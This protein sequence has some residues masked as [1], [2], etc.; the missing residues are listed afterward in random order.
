VTFGG[1][2][3]GGRL[4]FHLCLRCTWHFARPPL[5]CARQF[6]WSLATPSPPPPE[7]FFLV[8]PFCKIPF[9]FS[10]KSPKNVFAHILP[11]LAYTKRFIDIRAYSEKSSSPWKIQKE[12]ERGK[13][14]K[15][16]KQKQKEREIL[17]HPSVG[18][19]A[20]Q[21]ISSNR[22]SLALPARS[23]SPSLSPAFSPPT[24]SS[25]QWPTF[26]GPRI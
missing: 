12:R 20:S 1:L 4:H 26:E 13:E 22:S 11:Y 9:P 21:N 25:S 23:F 7:P 6:A 5:A 24:D 16:E 8:C 19:R 17:G 3:G 18:D 2:R 15:R 14:R 10:R